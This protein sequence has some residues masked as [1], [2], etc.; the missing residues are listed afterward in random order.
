LPQIPWL[1]MHVNDGT[2]LLE[3]GDFFRKEK[4]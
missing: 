4:I 1:E 3:D 2:V